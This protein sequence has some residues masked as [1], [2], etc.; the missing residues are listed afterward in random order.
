MPDIEG[1]NINMEI[2]YMDQEFDKFYNIEYDP[3]LDKSLPKSLEEKAEQ[4]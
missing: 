4:N 2:T 3:I 1:E